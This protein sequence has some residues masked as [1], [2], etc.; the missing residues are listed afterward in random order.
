M[1]TRDVPPPT[2]PS[3]VVDEIQGKSRRIRPSKALP[4]DRIAFQKQLDMLRAYA[5]AYET[6]GKAVT[7]AQIAEIV[8]M[9]ATTVPHA[10]TFFVDVGLLVRGEGGYVPASEVVGYNRAHHWDAQTAGQK[11][12]PILRG[13]WFANTLIPT[14]MFRGSIDDREAIG[15][16]A[17]ASGATPD[18]RGSLDALLDYLAVAGLVERDGGMVKKTVAGL[19][20][21]A[22]PS[23]LPTA[24]TV[25]VTPG[26][27]RSVL[28]PP[29]SVEAPPSA[30]QLLLNILDPQNMSEPEQDAVWTLLK[31]LK[32]S[33]REKGEG[34]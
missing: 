33:G 32:K 9:A 13:T 8:K 27:G 1:I 21:D 31:F 7:N 23:A 10:N 6:S 4:T 22:A 18:F 15:V 14:L 2:S 17:D 11:L 26:T 30:E 25:A 20:A 3:E 5:V 16:L 28:A 19:P 34:L 12:A 29:A 24:P